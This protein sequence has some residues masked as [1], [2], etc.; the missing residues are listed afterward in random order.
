MTPE[1]KHHLRLLIRSWSRN[2]HI[3]I[4]MFG[5]Q[6]IL[7]FAAT[8]F[9]LNHPEWF[10]SKG[11]VTRESQGKFSNALLTNPDELA[12]VENLRKDWGAT[13]ALDSFEIQNDEIRVVFKGPGRR[14][15]AIIRRPD[16]EM[17]I[18][19]ESY[20]LT[21]RLTELHRGA[22][23]GP[24]WSL[25]IDATALVLVA[26]ALTGLTLWLLVEK[27]RRLGIISLAACFLAFSVVYFFFVP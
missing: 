3:Y 11:P 8:G 26:T 6:A 15:D 17:T 20:G 25:L 2:L 12:V 9:M 14:Y 7:F 16:G 19:R 18:T 10:G 24:T 21:G 22:D 13:G 1:T 4:S 27:W 5:L 23:A